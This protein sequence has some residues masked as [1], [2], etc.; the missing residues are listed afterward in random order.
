MN[1]SK[2][3]DKGKGR[4]KR[5]FV[6]AAGLAVGAVAGLAVTVAGE[7]MAEWIV[8]HSGRYNPGPIPPHNP[9]EQYRQ[10]DTNPCPNGQQYTEWCG[11]QPPTYGGD[12]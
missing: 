9:Y 10:R 1:R 5:A 3:R 7:R 12:C 2:G 8:R 4:G 11:C 6:V